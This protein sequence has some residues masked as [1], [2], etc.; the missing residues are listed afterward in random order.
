MTLASAST[1]TLCSLALPLHPVGNMRSC[2][3]CKYHEGME[4]TEKKRVLE[5]TEIIWGCLN[6]LRSHSHDWVLL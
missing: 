3:G 1:L 6:E 2:P 5:G 4:N